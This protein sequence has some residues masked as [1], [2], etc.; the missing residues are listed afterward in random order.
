MLTPRGRATI[1][2]AEAGWSFE[3]MTKSMT[4]AQGEEGRTRRPS[5][6]TTP[7]PT[8]KHVASWEVATD[9]GLDSAGACHYG[10]TEGDSRILSAL[11]C[12]PSYRYEAYLH[13]H[14]IC[15]IISLNWSALHSTS[16]LNWIAWTAE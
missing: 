11:Q 15:T 6:R 3:G 13:K 10:W 9:P 7:R 4:R 5:I 1:P 16:Q 8:V 12:D 14:S 2:N